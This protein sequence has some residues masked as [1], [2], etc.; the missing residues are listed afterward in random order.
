LTG[1]YQATTAKN[2]QTYQAF[3]DAVQRVAVS[4]TAGSAP[5]TVQTSITY[6]FKDGRVIQ[7]R[8]SFGLVRDGGI[9]K[10]DSSM[11]LSSQPQ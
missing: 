10:I 1:Q 3:W 4:N 9:L 2:R 6:V 11:V 7:E 8:T 5:G